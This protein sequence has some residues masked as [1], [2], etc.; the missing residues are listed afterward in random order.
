MGLHHELL[1]SVTTSPINHDADASEQQPSWHQEIDALTLVIDSYA[2]NGVTSRQHRSSLTS[3][4]RPQ[5]R[6]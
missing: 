5:R 2:I 6:H 1:V 3:W 4:E